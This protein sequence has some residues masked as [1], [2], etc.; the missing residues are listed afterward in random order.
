M[1]FAVVELIVTVLLGASS[2]AAGYYWRGSTDELDEHVRVQYVDKPTIVEKIVEKVRVEYV[3]KPYAVEKVRV[4][5]V[6][7]P[8]IIEKETVR[9][10]RVAAPLAPFAAGRALPTTPGA[11]TVEVVLMDANETRV[12]GTDTI[13]ASLRRPTLLRDGVKFA[14]VR[15]DDA[16][17]WIYKQVAH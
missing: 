5:R 11:Q 8:H 15:Q 1:D 4:E 13:D 10:E 12:K 3:D 7:V 2:F 17:H 14:C 6:E 16:G 9:V